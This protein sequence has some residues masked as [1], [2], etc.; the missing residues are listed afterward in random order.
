[1]VSVIGFVSY[2]PFSRLFQTI[3][4]EG[5]MTKGYHAF[6]L[7]YSS[8]LVVSSIHEVIDANEEYLH[9]MEVIRQEKELFSS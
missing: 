8:S 3:E 9:W 5:E 2:S 4:N 6:F 1:M 7:C